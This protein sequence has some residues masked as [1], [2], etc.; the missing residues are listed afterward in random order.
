M[1][2]KVLLWNLLNC[3]ILGLCSYVPSD[4][5]M[6]QVPRNYSRAIFSNVQSEHIM[7]IRHEREET[8]T[9]ERNGNFFRNLDYSMSG[10]VVIH[11]HRNVDVVTG[12]GKHKH[13]NWKHFDRQ[14]SHE[15]PNISMED[16]HHDS[17]DMP[18]HSSGGNFT[19]PKDQ[20]GGR[21][22]IFRRAIELGK[23]P[24]LTSNKPI[25]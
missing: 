17:D 21:K 20:L 18:R 3:V 5:H 9:Q 6:K 2:N 1:H 10:K 7:Q 22:Y 24:L 13:K 25:S 16:I 4:K 19:T 15:S 14:S 11:Q 23:N 8:H 12:L